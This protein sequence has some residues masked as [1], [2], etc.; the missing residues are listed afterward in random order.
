MATNYLPDP[1]YANY[2]SLADFCDATFPEKTL[3]YRKFYNKLTDPA[4]RAQYP[5]I[6][7]ITTE[8]G[9]HKWVINKADF[10]NLQIKVRFQ[11]RKD[12]YSGRR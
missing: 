7:K 8:R 5:E 9:I 4:Y 1:Y 2:R 12:W 11:F 3:W 10:I 6:L